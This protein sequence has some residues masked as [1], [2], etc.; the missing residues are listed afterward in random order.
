MSRSINCLSSLNGIL[1]KRKPNKV[2]L[3]TSIVLA[4]KLS[5]AVEDI[6]TIV[7][8]P[9]KLIEIP[10]GEAAKDLS[11]LQ[12]V[13]LGFDRLQLNKESLILALGGGSVID[14]VG[15]ACSLYHRGIPNVNI[16]TTLLAQV[17]A[18]IGGKTA[19]NFNGHKNSIGAFYSPLF[20]IIDARF[21]ETLGREEVVDGLAEVIKAGLVKDFSILKLLESNNLATLMQGSLAKQL[22]SRAVAVKEYF[23]GVDPL[24]NGARQILNFGHTIGHALEIKHGLSHGRAVLLGMEEELKIGEALGKTDPEVRKFFGRILSNLGVSIGLERLVIDWESVLHDKKVSGVCIALPV[25]TKPGQSKL[26]KI[27]I[28]KL[29]DI[30]RNF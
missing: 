11:V 10:N 2:V 29:S 25:V 23:V 5:W 17:D 30:T 4:K 18:S 3:V 16:P 12:K 8:K 27:R 9:V 1:K 19:I 20:V 7:G 22:I 14:L 26:I 15:L 21:L 28:E 13:W 6:R 24:D